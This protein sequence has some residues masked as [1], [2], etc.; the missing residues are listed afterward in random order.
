MAEKQS[1]KAAATPTPHNRAKLGQIAPTVI[2]PGDG[3]RAEW[4]AQK[5]LKDAQIVSD[6]RKLKVFTGTYNSKPVTIMA[7]GMGMPSA[8]IYI[9]ELYNF[10][11]VEKIIRTGTCGA[12]Q[13][14]IAPGEMILAMSVSTDS[15]HAHQFELS[16][17]FSPPA[18]FELLKSAADFARSEKYKAH[19]GMVFSSDFFSAYNA[20]GEREWKAWAKMGALAQDMETYAL[21]CAAAFA[22]KKAL[23]ILTA[24]INLHTKKTTK[25]NDEAFIPMMLTAL[26]LA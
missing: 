21:Y 17:T 11:G 13:K 23:S 20:K 2:L 22:Q 14:E 4:A 6:V 19:I 25:N 24:T 12:L 1:S 3:E 15:N 9:H 5:F 10:Y 18:D 26:Q 8:G 7:S 16:G